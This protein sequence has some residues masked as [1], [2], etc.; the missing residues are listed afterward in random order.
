MPAEATAVGSVFISNY[1]PYSVWNEREVPAVLDALARPPLP[2]ATL[3]LYLHIPFCRQRC[4]CCYFKVYTEKDSSQ[5]RAYLDALAKEVSIAAAQP[6][7]ASRPLKFVYFG[8]GT[9][10]FISARDL[11]SL[12]T[13]IKAVMPWDGA[14]EVTFECEPGT[15]TLPKLEVIRKIGVTRLSLGVES[16]DDGIL[17]E[18]GR[19][20]LSAE[21]VRVVPWI[22]SLGFD[23]LNIDLIAGMVGETWDTWKESVRRTLEMEPDSVTIYQMELPYNTVYS[24]DLLGHRRELPV[25]DWDQKRAWNEH[26]FETFEAA[27]YEVSSAYTLVKKGRDCRFVYRDAV[28]HGSDMVGT[29]VASFGHISGIHYQNASEWGDWLARI[30]AGRLPVARALK[31]DAAQ[32]LVRETILQLKL[33]RLDPD[34]FRDKFS[35]DIRQRFEGPFETLRRQGMLTL[36]NGRIA[37]TRQGLL[38]VDF[39]LP[40]F[41]DAEYR[42]ARYA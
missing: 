10:S 29:G 28:W 35:V 21:I 7:I 1:P 4:K 18:N 32:R 36:S 22:R 15:L 23:Q 40:E 30:D 2:G 16:F 9:P 37:L 3:G 42:N 11:S 17:K 13:R 27:G 38:R 8:G 39:L 25:A 41:Y 14:E 12:V 33:G 6:A 31:T 20:H 5:V 34:Y 19:A 24:Q 26:A